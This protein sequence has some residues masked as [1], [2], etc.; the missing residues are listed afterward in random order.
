MSYIDLHTHTHC[1]DGTLSPEELVTKAKEAGLEA[2][3]ITDH[4]AVDG[5]KR[6]PSVNT[7][8][9]EVISGVELSA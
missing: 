3:A 4:D 2:L 5:V 6:A 9:L 8:G 1:S 7:P